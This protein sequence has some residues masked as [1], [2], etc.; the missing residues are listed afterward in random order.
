MTTPR[1]DFPELS[2][3][4][5]QKYYEM[6]TSPKQ[7]YG[8]AKVPLHLLPAIAEIEWAKAHKNGADKYGAFNWH[9][10][11][12]EALTYIAAAR[13]HLMAWMAGEEIAPDSGV[14]HLGHVMACCAILMDAS[15]AGMLID[16]RPKKKTAV[17][18]ALAGYEQDNKPPSPINVQEDAENL[19]TFLNQNSIPAKT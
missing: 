4:D 7:I 9:E 13:R 3:E 12:V 11:P 2:P 14:H 15:K 8:D 5:R 19:R 1:R 10:N 17:L 6:P 16:N 18:E